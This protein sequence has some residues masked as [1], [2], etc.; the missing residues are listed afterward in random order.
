MM[1]EAQKRAKQK[2]KEKIKYIRV[3]FYPTELD[4]WEHLQ[5]QDPKQTYIKN[6]IRE[7]LK[8]NSDSK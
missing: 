6:L 4:L 3:E 7:D 8:R 2:Y 1:T 5:K